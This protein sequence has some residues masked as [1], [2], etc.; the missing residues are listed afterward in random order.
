M[1]VPVQVCAAQVIGLSSSPRE[2]M[3]VG[4]LWGCLEGHLCVPLVTCWVRQSGLKARLYCLL[5]NFLNV[6]INEGK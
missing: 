2:G 3:A 4:L 5:E 1:Q 6:L